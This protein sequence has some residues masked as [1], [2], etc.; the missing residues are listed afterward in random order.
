MFKFLKKILFTYA[1]YD[2][3][4]I[5]RQTYFLSGLNNSTLSYHVIKNV[6][7]FKS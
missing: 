7:L 4:I 3:Y 1:L 6:L 2:I 5:T